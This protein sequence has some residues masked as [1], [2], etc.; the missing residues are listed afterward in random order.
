M[1]SFAVVFAFQERHGQLLSVRQRSLEHRNDGCMALYVIDTRQGG[2][3]PVIRRAA[4]SV[5]RW[6]VRVFCDKA[7]GSGDLDSVRPFEAREPRMIAAYFGRAAFDDPCKHPH[8]PLQAYAPR[9]ARHTAVHKSAQ[10]TLTS[11]L[12][13]QRRRRDAQQHDK[14][15]LVLGANGGPLARFQ[16]V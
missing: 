16:S 15:A 5:R 1:V 10:A 4:T 11:V 7:A 14:G 9:E 13:S 12:F 8:T 6:P 3:Y 2:A